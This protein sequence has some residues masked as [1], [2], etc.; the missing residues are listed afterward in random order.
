MRENECY[1]VD[2]I[3][4]L[5]VVEGIARLELFHY[6]SGKKKEGQNEPE[7]LP[8]GQVVMP[9]NG[10]VR[11]HDAVGRLIQDMTKRAAAAKETSGSQNFPEK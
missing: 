3:E 10:L 7:H 8:S 9:L 5:S 1:F 6:N 11:L 2:G 4:S